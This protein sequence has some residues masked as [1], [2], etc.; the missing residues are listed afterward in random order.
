MKHQQFD[1]L[2][3]QHNQDQPGDQCSHLSQGSHVTAAFQEGK[4]LEIP[5]T[6]ACSCQPAQRCPAISLK[7][8]SA[9]A[10]SRSHSPLPARLADLSSRG[11]QSGTASSVCSCTPV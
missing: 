9:I 1:C 6:E 4:P 2:V 11:N 3:D 8:S 7:E 10:K 5:D